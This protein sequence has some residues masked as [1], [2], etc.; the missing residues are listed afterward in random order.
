[1][2]H[3]Q[4]IFSGDIFQK[5]GLAKLHSNN[6]NSIDKP[7]VF[8]HLPASNNANGYE[9]GK[10][11]HCIVRNVM[12]YDANI[13]WDD[14]VVIMRNNNENKNQIFTKLPVL[15]G[16]DIYH[17]TTKG[18]DKHNTLDWNKAKGK[19]KLVSIHGMKG[20]GAKLVIFLGFSQFSI[21]LEKHVGTEN[22][23]FDM[24]LAYVALTRSTKYLFIGHTN[25][26]SSQYIEPALN[27]CDPN[28]FY[29]VETKRKRSLPKIYDIIATELENENKHNIFYKKRRENETVHKPKPNSYE[30][31]DDIA[32]RFEHPS[33]LGFICDFVGEKI[34]ENIFCSSIDEE[35]HSI[36][37]GVMSEL[38]IQKKLNKELINYYAMVQNKKIQFDDDHKFICLVKDYY[39]FGEKVIEDLKSKITKNVS[40][41]MNQEYLSKLLIAIESNAI[42]MHSSCKK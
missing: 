33:E 2:S 3:S 39:I 34:A 7:F 21:P 40:K 4:I 11:I 42:Y 9:I 38:L 5:Y 28:L 31:R 10:M 35:A 16:N 15:F 41:K 23:L 27:D 12:K 18:Q 22:E 30:I 26:C 8:G 14:I 6:D 24:S 19:M 1:M 29:S 32:C 25:F 37:L 20:K 36:I 13:S 17:M